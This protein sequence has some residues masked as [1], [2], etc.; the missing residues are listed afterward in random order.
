[1]YAVQAAGILNLR[2]SVPAVFDHEPKLKPTV[3][4]NPDPIHNQKTYRLLQFGR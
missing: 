3:N 4:P 2:V 1:M